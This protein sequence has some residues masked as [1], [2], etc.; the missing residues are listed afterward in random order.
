MPKLYDW[1]SFD[2]KTKVGHNF[3]NKFKLLWGHSKTK[4][5]KFWPST[6]LEWT[7][8][9]ILFKFYLS[10]VTWP[11]VDFLPP[12]LVHIVIECPLWYIRTYSF[13]PGLVNWGIPNGAA[14]AVNKATIK[15]YILKNKWRNWYKYIYCESMM[16]TVH[17]TATAEY[18]HRKPTAAYQ[19]RTT[20]YVKVR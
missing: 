4:W 10:F 17:C 12:L 9:D 20:R 6:P 1:K 8:M 2:N 11:S 14:S 5:T 18:V 3:S 7:K 16:Y 19:W 13:N 15:I